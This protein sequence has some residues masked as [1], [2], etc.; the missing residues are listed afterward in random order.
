M[1][2]TGHFFSKKMYLNTKEIDWNS[3]VFYHGTTRGYY[4]NQIKEH[5]KFQNSSAGILLTKS[6]FMAYLTA[7]ERSL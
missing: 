4:E 7:K 2:R 1:S 5:G 6:R 3:E